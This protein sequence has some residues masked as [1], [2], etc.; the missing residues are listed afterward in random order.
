LPWNDRAYNADMPLSDIGSL[1]PYH[2][3]VEPKTVVSA[4][5]RMIDDVSSGETVFYRFYTDAQMQEHAAPKGDRTLLLPRKARRPVPAELSIQQKRL[6][7]Q[8]I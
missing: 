7:P 1:L 5:N 2:S 4:L 6:E 8:R 3:H